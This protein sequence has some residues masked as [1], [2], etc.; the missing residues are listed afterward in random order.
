M[1]HI[2]TF[3]ADFI[4]EIIVAIVTVWVCLVISHLLHR[5]PIKEMRDEI[6]SLKQGKGAGNVVFKAGVNI[7]YND[8]R[9]EDGNYHI[10]FD[11]KGEIVSP[12]PIEVKRATAQF[13]TGSPEIRIKAKASP[14]NPTETVDKT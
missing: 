5:K 6:K 9:S 13:S 3:V 8:F 1:E 11:G 4:S 7:T 12:K 14:K 2:S 10:R